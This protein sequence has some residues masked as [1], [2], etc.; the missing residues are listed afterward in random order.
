MIRCHRYDQTAVNLIL[1]N[2]FNLTV[3]NAELII[4]RNYFLLAGVD[5][6][7]KPLVCER[8]IRKSGLA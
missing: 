3:V 6:T 5:L 1:A 4:M 7:M 8:K 2:I